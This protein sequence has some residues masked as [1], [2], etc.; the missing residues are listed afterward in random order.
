MQV[1]LLPLYELPIV[2]HL[3]SIHD[4]VVW[5][6]LVQPLGN[7][8]RAAIESAK[9]VVGNTR[10]ERHNNLLVLY[11]YLSPETGTLTDK[12]HSSFNF[13][14]CDQFCQFLYNH[15]VVYNKGCSVPPAGGRRR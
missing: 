1:N 11:L 2:N 13:T 12:G 10:I 14:A 5:K 15:S 8:R 9:L 4:S 3:K 7:R 6:R